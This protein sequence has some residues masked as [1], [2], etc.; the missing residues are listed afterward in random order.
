MSLNSV[1]ISGYLGADADLRAG[2]SG[3]SVLRF[4]VAVNERKKQSDGNYADVPHWIDCVMFGNRAVGLQPYL[5]KGSK[6]SLLGH[7]S[8]STYEKDGRTIKSVSV[9]VD[10]VEL[11]NSKGNNQ[12]QSHQEQTSNYSYATDQ[13]YEYAPQPAQT[14]QAF[15]ASS[16]PNPFA[17]TSQQAASAMEHQ[18]AY[19]DDDIPF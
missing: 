10:E 7:L 18:D 17:S 16:M 4:S 1:T 2:Q 5:R 11:Q 13:A 12:Q 19:A 6:L 15:S 9:I 8:T 3:V 14:D